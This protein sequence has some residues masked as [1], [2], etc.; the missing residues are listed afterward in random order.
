MKRIAL[1]I[2]LAICAAASVKAADGDLFPYPTPP[3]DM[4]N[5]DERCDFIISRFWRQCDFKSALSKQDKLRSTF[6]DWISLMPYA[7]ADTVHAAIDQVIAKNAKS[8]PLTLALARMAEECVY[9]D[10]AE[11]VSAEIFLPFAKAAAEHKKI[12]AADRKHFAE[13]VQKIENTTNGKPVKHF[14]IIQPDGIKG[15]LDNYRT[16]IVVLLFN[17]HKNTDSS[18]T[19]V[20]LSADHNINQMIEKGLVTIVSVEPGPANNEWLAATATY[21]NNWVIGAMPDANDWF[22]LQSDGS[23][24]IYMLDGRHRI[25][26]KGLS[27]DSLMMMIAHVRQQSGL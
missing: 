11:V 23:P 16:Q 7:N 15:T 14:E 9:S 3:D 20:R 19:R 26:S 22:E 2:I 6:A 17:S 8:G 25:L 12:N 27:T 10:S 18:I 24:T 1:Y 21:P 4:E 13:I 5:L